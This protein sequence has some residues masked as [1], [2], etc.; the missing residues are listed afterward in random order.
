MVQ[1]TRL[2]T[3]EIEGSNPSFP[4]KAVGGNLPTANP[5][6]ASVNLENRISW[7]D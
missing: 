7:G 3:V 2:S 6:G 1:D 5:A 4:T